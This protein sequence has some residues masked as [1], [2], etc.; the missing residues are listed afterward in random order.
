MELFRIGFLSVGVADLVDIGLV[1][2]IFYRL[3]MAMRGS[4][5]AQIFIGL[6]LIVLLSFTVQAA[7]LKAMGWLLRTLTDICVIA[8]II[9]F[10]PELRRLLVIIARS[11]AVR[12]FFKTN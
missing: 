7:N 9:L 6:V 8:F 11:P 3:Y 10:Q 5:A 1:S 4:I 12:L 2:F